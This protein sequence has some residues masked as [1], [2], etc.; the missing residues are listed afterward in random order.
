MAQDI[1][2]TPSKV[3]RILLGEVHPKEIESFEAMVRYLDLPEQ[4]ANI[5]R[6]EYAVERAWI[7][8][9][10]YN[11]RQETMRRNRTET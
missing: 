4:A 2:V 7:Q 3:S 10:A 9:R 8:A 6:A 11:L 5:L 1:D